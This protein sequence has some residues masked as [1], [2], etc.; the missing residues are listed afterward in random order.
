MKLMIEDFTEMMETVKNYSKLNETPELFEDVN[1]NQQVV[2][3]L[4]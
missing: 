1:K 4:R 2:K 3:G